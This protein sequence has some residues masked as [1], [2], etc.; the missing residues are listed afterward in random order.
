MPC[1]FERRLN[2]LGPRAS[3][4]QW[5]AKRE[6]IELADTLVDDHRVTSGR[7]ARGPSNGVEL[8]TSLP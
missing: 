2:L 5:S 3:R 4:P 7:D 8:F 1:R 6:N